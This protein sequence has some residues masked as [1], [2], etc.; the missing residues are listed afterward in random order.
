[1]YKVAVQIPHQIFTIN[2]QMV[3]GGK[4]LLEGLGVTGK[5]YVP[6]YDVP[7]NSQNVAHIG[8]PRND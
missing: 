4:L 2:L 1:M 3:E 7:R 5:D 8:N 6:K